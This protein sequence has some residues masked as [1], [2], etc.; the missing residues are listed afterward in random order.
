[1]IEIIP[2]IM[3][4]NYDDLV[5]K[6]GRVKGI[7][8]CAQI[9]VMDGKFV[10]SV[11]WPYDKQ[12]KT[13]FKSMIKSGEML[14]FWEDISYEVDLM[15]EH[16]ERVVLDWISLGAHRII[17]HIESVG[18]PREVLSLMED[19]VLKVED[20]EGCAPTQ[21]VI[22]L[23]TDTSFEKLTPYIHDLDAVQL[24]GIKKIGYQ[25]E[26]FDENVIE[27]IKSLREEH[28]HLIISIDGGV[29]FET[30]PKLIKAGATRLV[31]GSAIFESSDI[32]GTIFKLK[33]I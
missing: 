12:G 6:A 27:R 24:M 32:R 15:V 7:V 2:A 17:I 4:N 25:G 18:D 33:Q 19:V 26:P 29:S 30:A 10:P 9:D 8:A 20:C 3:P 21:F 22:A 13:Q 31:S 14:P 1:M 11:S 16:P 5:Q 28:P 23:N